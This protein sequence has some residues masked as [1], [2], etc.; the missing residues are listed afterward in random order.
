VKNTDEVAALLDS[1]VGLYKVL[2]AGQQRGQ[3]SLDHDSV[4]SIGATW[5]D[6][7]R[8]RWEVHRRAQ[9]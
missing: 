5:P 2:L 9:Q 3:T 6:A 1:P 4:Y 8:A 7:E